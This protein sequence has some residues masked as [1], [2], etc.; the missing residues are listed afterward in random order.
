MERMNLDP[1]LSPSTKVNSKSITDLHVRV[2]KTLRR[3][4][5]GNLF[6]FGISN[7]FLDSIPKVQEIREIVG[8]LDFIKIKAL[9]VKGHHQESKTATHKV[10]ENICK[11]YF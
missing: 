7:D 9:C 11:S 1:C 2:Y 6:D 8:K 3:K 10:K 4:H 5:K